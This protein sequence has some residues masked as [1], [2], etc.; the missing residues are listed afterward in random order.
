MNKTMK[1]NF[2][3]KLH[4]ACGTDDLC[5]V[6]QF[7]IFE[8]G[9]AVCTDAH[10][11][12]K[13]SLTLHD[14]TPEEVAIMN[15]KALHMDKFKEVLRYQ[16]VEAK[17]EGLQC[18]KGAV[19][20]L[21]KWSDLDGI[22]PRYKEVIPKEGQGCAVQRIGMSLKLLAKLK[23]I[24]INENIGAELYFHGDSRAVIVTTVTGGFT[25]E[26]IMVMPVALK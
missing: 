12:V 23:D 5:P 20:V 1:K 7:V 22:Y 25:D 2:K 10:M 17:E 9:N 8:D 18:E 13:Q 19:N 4:L 14:F 21:I 11:L 24:A 3:T 15:G 16:F 6:I 26:L